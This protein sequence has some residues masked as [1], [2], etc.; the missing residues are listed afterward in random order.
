MPYGSSR[1]LN[2]F[3]EWEDASFLAVY[4]LKLRMLNGETG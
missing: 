3:F 1:R 4:L 2:Y